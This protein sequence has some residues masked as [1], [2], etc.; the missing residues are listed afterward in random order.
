MFLCSDNTSNSREEQCSE[1]HR[2]V[3]EHRSYNVFTGSMNQ[4]L[5]NTK[6]LGALAEVEVC[7]YELTWHEHL[8]AY[9]FTVLD[10]WSFHMFGFRF[11]AAFAGRVTDVAS[12]W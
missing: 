4:T 10:V 7:G 12:S 9:G 5:L 6:G 1:K 8:K 2:H 3:T 11:S